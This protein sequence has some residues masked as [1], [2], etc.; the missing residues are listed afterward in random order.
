MPLRFEITQNCN[1]KLAV[2]QARFGPRHDMNQPIN[3]SQ[4]LMSGRSGHSSDTI[5]DRINYNARN[6]TNV[7]Y[8]NTALHLRRRA[9]NVVKK[10]LSLQQIGA[11]LSVDEELL[12]VHDEAVSDGVHR[13][14]VACHSQVLRKLTVHFV[15]F[16]VKRQPQTVS[17]LSF[18]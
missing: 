12:L 17:L 1:S 4:Q 14:V 16:L 9:T 8:C 7:T 18:K 11:V 15:E 10:L 2:T 5:R 3:G 13:L 6:T